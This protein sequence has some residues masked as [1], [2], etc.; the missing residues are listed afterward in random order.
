MNTIES[1][2]NAFVAWYTIRAKSVIQN[3]DT[4]EADAEVLERVEKLHIVERLKALREEKKKHNWELILKAVTVGVSLLF[5]IFL[6]GCIFRYESF[7][8]IITKCFGFVR[9]MPL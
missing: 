1:N 3:T 6:V 4:A 9:P 7:A 5:N 8:P 2:Y